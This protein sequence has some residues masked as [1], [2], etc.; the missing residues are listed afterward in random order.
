[1]SP[2]PLFALILLPISAVYMFV[3]WLIF[4]R[5]VTFKISAALAG[6]LMIVAFVAFVIGNKGFGELLWASPLVGAAFVLTYWG[7]D[8]FVGRPLRR[9]YG[10]LYEMAEGEGDLSRSLDVHTKDEIGRISTNFNSL[11]KKLSGII[12]SLR[13]VGAKGSS[14]GGELAASSEELSATIEE[15]T[16]TI[17]AMSAKISAQS[18][19][20]ARSNID[21]KEI[22]KA[23]ARLGELIDEEAISISESSASIEQML[24][25]IRNIEAVTASKKVVSDRLAAL[26]KDGASGMGSTV[27]EIDEIARSAETIFDLVRMIDD[28]ASRTNLLAMNASIEAAHAG[29]YGKGFAV[30]ADEIRKLAETTGVNS[31]NISESLKAIVAKITLTSETT[32]KTGAAIGEIISGIVDVSDG[33]NETLTGMREL[34]LGSERIT[35]ALDGLVRISGEV[36]ANSRAMND[37]TG[38]VGASMDSLSGLAAENKAGMAEMALGAAEISKAVLSLA[39]LSAENAENMTRLEAEITRFKTE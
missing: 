5:T 11:V 7:I 1:M 25:S 18:G 30:V 13:S 38:R 26:A 12:S 19:E 32:K 28:I 16:M 15:M 37:M 39:G 20:I 29:A 2:I 22:K 27:A 6:S 14:I 4:K 9:T 24:A 31:R 8:R 33:M 10:A 23:I 17:E 36:R 34:S 3:L 35:E 21:V